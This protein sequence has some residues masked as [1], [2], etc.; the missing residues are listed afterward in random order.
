MATMM[1]GHLVLKMA[2]HLAVQ[3]EK[4]SAKQS[5]KSKWT[6]SLTAIEKNGNVELKWSK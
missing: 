5:A 2:C 1:A 3:T 4:K 6:G